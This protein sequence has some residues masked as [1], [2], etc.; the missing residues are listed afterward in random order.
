MLEFLHRQGF[1]QSEIRSLH[2][3]RWLNEP[4]PEASLPQGYIIRAARGEAEVE[5]LVE[6]HRAAFKSDWMTLE[7]RLGMMR[8]AGYLP[9]LD[10][11]IE[12]PQG[13]LAA[14]CVGSVDEAE[15]RE[16]GTCDGYTDPIGVHPDDQ[17]RGFGRAILLR[18]LA[19]LKARGLERARL[20]TS[21]A[22]QGMQRLAQAV[23]FRV[24]EEN[25]WFSKALDEAG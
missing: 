4:I 2:Y 17:R 11:V 7:Y 20:G 15:N 23:G 13:E 6:L 18:A 1:Q 19:L 14:F 5:R 8:G 22:N 10:L 12:T 9:E 24:V 16:N 25:L 3:A 21:N